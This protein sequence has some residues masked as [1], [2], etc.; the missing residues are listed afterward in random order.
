MKIALCL[1]LTTTGCAWQSEA[2]RLGEDTYQTSANASPTINAD[3]SANQSTS[4]T[5]GPNGASRQTGSL[6]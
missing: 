2:M 5:C 4:P 1:L 3:R 6:P